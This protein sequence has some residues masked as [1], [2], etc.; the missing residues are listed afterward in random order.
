MLLKGCQAPLK[1]YEGAVEG[2]LHKWIRRE[3]KR[4]GNKRRWA[5]PRNIKALYLHHSLLQGFGV[6]FFPL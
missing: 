5:S 2:R 4:R 6:V 3:K 1:L